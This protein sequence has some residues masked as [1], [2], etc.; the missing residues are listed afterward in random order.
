MKELAFLAVGLTLGVIIGRRG[1]E[2]ERLVE[3]A[4][5]NSRKKG[6]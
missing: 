2:N 4:K 6:E 1:A 3:E 5:I